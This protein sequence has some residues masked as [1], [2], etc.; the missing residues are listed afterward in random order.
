MWVSKFGWSLVEVWCRSLVDM[1][2]NWQCG[3]CIYR[4]NFDPTSTLAPGV[5]VWSEFGRSF[6]MSGVEFWSKFRP[7]FD[8]PVSKFGLSD[9]DRNHQEIIFVSH[10][11]VGCNTMQ[12]HACVSPYVQA[13]NDAEAFNM[14]S[15]EGKHRSVL[16]RPF[17]PSWSRWDHYWARRLVA[18]KA[19]TIGMPRFTAP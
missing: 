2:S 11:R 17:R 12:A 8:P 1:L 18:V 13:H 3:P 10:L 14:G 6:D 5:E 15:K 16:P 19:W 7:N 9:D 4:A